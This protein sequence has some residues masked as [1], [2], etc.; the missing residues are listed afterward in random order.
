MSV[1]W[2]GTVT[3][4]TRK[5]WS[6]VTDVSIDQR[7]YDL[8]KRLGYEGHELMAKAQEFKDAIKRQENL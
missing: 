7:A 1:I 6:K 2:G 8:A 5:L 4:E 3:E